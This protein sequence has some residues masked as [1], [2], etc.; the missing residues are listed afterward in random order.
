M[1]HC[2]TTLAMAS[3]LSNAGVTAPLFAGSFTG[4][5]SLLTGLS[6]L[7]P[8]FGAWLET[9]PNISGFTNDAGYLQRRN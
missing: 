2:F 6:E 4:D 8:V 9:M 1:A 5:G 3:W 7:D